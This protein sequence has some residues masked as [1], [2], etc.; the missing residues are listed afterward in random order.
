MSSV[1]KIFG[2]TDLATLELDFIIIACGTHDTFE[3]CS[4]LSCVEDVV[5]DS[6]HV[7]RDHVPPVPMWCGRSLP[8]NTPE[9]QPTNGVVELNPDVNK[10]ASSTS[11]NDIV[12]DEVSGEAPTTQM[13][14][15]MKITDDIDK[16]LQS[17]DLLW[18]H[19][20]CRW[21][22]PRHRFT[23]RTWWLTYKKGLLFPSE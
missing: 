21:H 19:T 23:Q 10:R 20:Y 14:P 15:H 12:N 22:E 4:P 2:S 5:A 11:G 6:A 17:A 1:A 13:P 7:V 3:C 18:K 8:V 9:E 16:R